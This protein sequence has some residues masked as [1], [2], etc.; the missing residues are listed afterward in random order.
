MARFL[1]VDDEVPLLN[2]TTRILRARG[3]D[4]RPFAEGADAVDALARAGFDV[5]VTDL[6]MPHMNGE[7]IVHATRK[8]APG[9]CVIVAT[10][11][12]EVSSTDRCG[13]ACMVYQKPID[14]T[15][16][17]GHVENCRSLGGARDG[18]CPMRARFTSP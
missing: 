4:V 6:D 3:H 17:V 18:A 5:V 7:A 15:A 2:V 13:G 14:Y 8:A 1:V 16:L 11:N 10:G 12:P 9:A